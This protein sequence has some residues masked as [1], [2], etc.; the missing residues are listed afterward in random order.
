MPTTPAKPGRST[1]GPDALTVNGATGVSEVT[2]IGIVSAATC[3]YTSVTVAVSVSVPFQLAHL[4]DTA[5]VAGF[6]IVQ[7]ALD[8]VQAADASRF[9]DGVVGATV[10]EAARAVIVDGPVMV[11]NGNDRAK[12]DDCIHPSAS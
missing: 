4:T 2:A 3:P 11:A 7:A 10:Y 12:T 5:K 1:L 9:E 8:D 6:V